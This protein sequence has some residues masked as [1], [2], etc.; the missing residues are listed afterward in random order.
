MKGIEAVTLSCLVVAV[1]AS[2]LGGFFPGGGIQGAGFHG[3]GHHGGGIHH[4]GALGGGIH[5]GGVHGG[6]IQPGGF[7]GGGIQGG[8]IPGA[9]GIIG[10]GISNGPSECRYWCRT[11]EN[12][13]YCCETA[14][15]PETP[16]GTKFLECPDVRPTCPQSIR[17]GG[18][19]R[20][21]NDYKCANFD[22]CCYDRC[23]KEHVCKPPSI[24]GGHF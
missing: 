18:P 12:Q 17:A 22:K 10:G 9:S 23:L 13:A 6:G 1:S 7:H 3:S 19:V 8:V 15:E 14:Y 24:F 5:P 21:S 4:G 11:P 2:K 16:V 20:C